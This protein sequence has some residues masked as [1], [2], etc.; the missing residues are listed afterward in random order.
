MTAPRHQ[1]VSAAAA[2][3]TA[4]LLSWTGCITLD[5]FRLA[6]PGRVNT[7]ASRCAVHGAA[8]DSERG[9]DARKTGAGVLADLEHVIRVPGNPVR[10]RAAERERQPHLPV[11]WR[12]DRRAAAAVARRTDDGAADPAR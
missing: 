1:S 6:A 10:L 12:V 8:G 11:A 2:G 9:T 5:S 3:S 7:I 4:S